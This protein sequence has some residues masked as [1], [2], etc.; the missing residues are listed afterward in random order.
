MKSFDKSLL[1]PEGIKAAA[2]RNLNVKICLRCHA[3]NS[4]RA[5]KC[6]KCGYKNLRVKSKQSDKK[7][8]E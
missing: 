1:T 8:K 6:R 7:H 3:H 2:N 5:V 4:I